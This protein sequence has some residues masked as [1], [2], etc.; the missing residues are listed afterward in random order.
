VT[1]LSGKGLDAHRGNSANK[2]PALRKI[3]SRINSIGCIYKL[4]EQIFPIKNNW[5][6]RKNGSARIVKLYVTI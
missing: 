6:S 2:W 4:K 1:L 5:L 3:K